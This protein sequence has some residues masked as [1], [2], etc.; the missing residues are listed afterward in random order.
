[1]ATG[2]T[3]LC[4]IE[5]LEAGG[6]QRQ[7]IALASGVELED[8]FVL[9]PSGR[10]LMG[11]PETENWRIEDEAQHEVSVSAVFLPSVYQSSGSASV[12]VSGS[13]QIFTLPSL[14]RE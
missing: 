11:S 9:I 7:L 3:I 13:N 14:R 5:S 4:F 12:T 8:G 10:F 1:M 6:A 2:K